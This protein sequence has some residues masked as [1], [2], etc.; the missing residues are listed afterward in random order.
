[1]NSE[2]GVADGPPVF[3]SLAPPQLLRERVYEAI[4]ASIV[5]GDLQPGHHLREDDLARQLGVSRNPVREALQR[6]MHEGLVDHRQSRGIFVHTP[7]LTEVE[8]VFVVRA[9][10]EG[11]CARL[12]AQNATPEAIRGLED[13]L[14]RGTRAVERKEADRLLELNEE[15]HGVLLDLAQN[16]LM[17]SMMVSLRR[18]IRWYFAGVVV[19]R[20]ERSWDQHRAM[21]EAIKAGD[22]DTAAQIMR[23]HVR[24]TGSAIRKK[25]SDADDAS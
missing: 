19:Q 13:L 7:T 15:F 6:L 12:A 16:S 10:L 2:R 20:S 17:S 18:R 24:H 9:L 25:L 4:E 3:G 21:Y 1:M 23:E 14:E 11:E 5:G 22:G 8:E